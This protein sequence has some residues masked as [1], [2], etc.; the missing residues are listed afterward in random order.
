M[1]LTALTDVGGV[2]SIRSFTRSWQRAAGFQEVIPQRPAFIFAPD[3]AP[4]GGHEPLQWGRSGV[5]TEGAPRQ[6][7]LRQHFEASSPSEASRADSN[8]AAGPSH[9]ERYP[10]AAA[11]TSVE[12]DFRGR[13]QKAVDNDLLKAFEVGSGT[14]STSIF[15]IPPHLAA[16]P[17][18]GS[19][20]SYNNYGAVQ[21]D[22]SRPSMAEAGEL[23]RRD[24][25]PG[26][27]GPDEHSE[28]ILVKEVEQDGK[29]VLTVEG[30]STL[31][32]TIF[33]STNVLIGVGLLSL[34]LGI[35]YAGWLCGLL[36]LSACAAVTSY[37]ARLLARCMDLDPSLITFS[38]LAFISFGRNARI[39]TSFLFTLE[40]LAACV[41]LFVLFADS[42][43]LL[44]PDFV[45]LT[46][47]KVLCALVMIPL[48]FLPLRLLSFTS[49]IGILSCFGS[50][51]SN[52]LPK[53][54]TVARTHAERLP[55]SCLSSL[56]TG[57][58][59]RHRRARWL[60]LPR[61]I[62]FQQIGSLVRSR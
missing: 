33:N 27:S 21:S 57:F 54:H 60:S 42:L 30:Q 29:F 40:L 14:T 3:Q 55:Q 38:D 56:L 50:K 37:T 12:T 10:A 17:I 62:Y 8:E 1:R 4:I 61:R 44:F 51:S 19:Y 5:E 58:G 20:S 31:P 35:R 43:V 46:E 25:A 11:E 45:T 52:F 26:A 34:P 2:N 18:I 47:W 59:R 53:S 23:W 6:S 13:E 7:L 9:D 24:H 49:V 28:P 39:A 36:M 48:S 15:G 32:Q 22:I 41:A 16:P